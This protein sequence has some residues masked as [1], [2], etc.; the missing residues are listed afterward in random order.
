MSEI[1]SKY[2]FILYYHHLQNLQ[3]YSATQKISGD[4]KKDARIYTHLD[5]RCAAPPWT[6]LPCYS[7]K[8]DE[9]LFMAV[10]NCTEIRESFCDSWEGK[11]TITN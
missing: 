8:R 11:G 7:K 5:R 10:Q 9:D 3:N 2:P 1:V 6:M 4:D